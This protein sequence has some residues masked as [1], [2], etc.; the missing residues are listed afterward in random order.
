MWAQP[1]TGLSRGSHFVRRVMDP[2]SNPPRN[3]LNR[4]LGHGTDP[5][6]QISV[7]SFACSMAVVLDF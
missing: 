1:R 7:R 3:R 4:Y 5:L 2:Q 6:S